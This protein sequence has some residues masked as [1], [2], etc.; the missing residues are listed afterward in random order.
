[1]QA[2]DVERAKAGI[3]DGFL[4]ALTA[5]GSP[6]D[7]RAGVERYA[8]PAR[9]RRASARVPRTDFMPTLEAAAPYGQITPAR[10]PAGLPYLGKVTADQRIRSIQLLCSP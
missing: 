2:G 10:E 1:M 9:P 6:E 8:R 5:I 7:V 4:E 3:S